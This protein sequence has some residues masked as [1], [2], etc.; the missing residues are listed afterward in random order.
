MVLISLSAHYASHS[1]QQDFTII[2]GEYTRE[3]YYSV[4]TVSH[5]PRG[6]I[7]ILNVSPG[8]KDTHAIHLFLQ[9]PNDMI[10]YYGKNGSNYWTAGI[11]GYYLKI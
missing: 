1:L 8:R 9:L 5:Y 4:H 7:L 2:C 11:L 3:F 6:F 10:Y